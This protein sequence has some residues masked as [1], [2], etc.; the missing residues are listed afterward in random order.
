MTT[1]SNPDLGRNQDS[2]LACSDVVCIV[3]P[4]RR[5]SRLPETIIGIVADVIARK[6]ITYTP[7]S[8]AIEHCLIQIQYLENNTIVRRLIA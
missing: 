4:P 1:S 2:N 7:H 8:N 3:A 6:V 5:P